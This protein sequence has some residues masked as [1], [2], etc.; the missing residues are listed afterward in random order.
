MGGPRVGPIRAWQDSRAVPVPVICSR[1][2]KFDTEGNCNPVERW[3]E[4]R[5]P[6]TSSE[7]LTNSA[8]Y[9]GAS[10]FFSQRVGTM[11]TVLKPLARFAH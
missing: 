10:T 3:A 2:M 6:Q 7:N 4:A 8:T 11:S 9:A 5:K 1:R